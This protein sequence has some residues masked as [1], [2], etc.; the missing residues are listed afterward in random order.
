MIPCSSYGNEFF[1]L[2]KSAHQ[3][4]CEPEKDHEKELKYS[5]STFQR[6]ADSLVFDV[7]S[8]LPSL[9]SFASLTFILVHAFNFLLCTP[10]PP[11]C[12]VWMSR[13]EGVSAWQIELMFSFPKANAYFQM[14]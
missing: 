6:C 11:Y 2:H 4:D 3:D 12:F 10:N 8:S 13:R 14:D 7:H 9:A 5:F 1:L